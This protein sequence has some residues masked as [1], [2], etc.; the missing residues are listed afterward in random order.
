[1]N[2]EE[3]SSQSVEVTLRL[4]STNDSPGIAAL[5]ADA[6]AEYEPLY[7]PEGFAATTITADEVTQRMSDGP[8]WVATCENV[9]VGT[10]SVVR[11]EDSLYVRGMAVHPKARGRSIGRLLLTEIE[12]YA[13]ANGFRRLFLSTTPFLVRAIQLY[14]KSGYRRTDAGPYDLFSTPLFTMEKFLSLDKFR[15][16]S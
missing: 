12:L 1:M 4:A 10:I 9:I 5:L 16:I 14:E 15:K 13:A 3:G 11:K 2:V 7:T 6:F 8:V